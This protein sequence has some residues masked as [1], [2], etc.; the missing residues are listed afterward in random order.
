VTLVT[1]VNPESAAVV[2]RRQAPFSKAAS[3]GEPLGLA[4]PVG[5]ISLSHVALPFPPDDPLY[6]QRPPENEDVLFLG[7]MAIQGERGLLILPS[8]W[9]LRLRH[10]PFYPYLE[11]RVL[12]WLAE[13]GGDGAESTGGARPPQP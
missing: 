13:A 3:P 7:Q 6:G 1:N 9:L 2:A 12:A 10:N 11:E 5:V 8:D 4:W